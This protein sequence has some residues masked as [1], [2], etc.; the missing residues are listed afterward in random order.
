MVPSWRRRVSPRGGGGKKR[1][2]EDGFSAPHISWNR[3]SILRDPIVRISGFQLKP[4]GQLSLSAILGRVN[5]NCLDLLLDDTPPPVFQMNLA[6][7]TATT[8][9]GCSVGLLGP[10][11]SE[12]EAIAGGGSAVEEAQI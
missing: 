6:H 10:Q 7:R 2:N 5:V 8:L 1:W 4:L 11:K 12:A 9:L 3:A